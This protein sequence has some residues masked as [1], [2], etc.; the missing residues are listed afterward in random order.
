MT[1][2]VPL[3]GRIF[4]REQ[5]HEIKRNGTGRD[6]GFLPKAS[7]W[8]ATAVL[9]LVANAQAGAECKLPDGSRIMGGTAV[10]QQDFPWQVALYAEGSFICGGSLIAAGWVLTAAH[11]VEADLDYEPFNV[12]L[13]RPSALRVRHGATDLGAKGGTWRAVAAVHAH[14]RYNGEVGREGADGDIALLR[15]AAPVGNAEKAYGGL[16]VSASAAAKLVVPGTCAL[17]SG[18]GHRRPGGSVSKQLQAASV[19]IVDQRTCRAQL[20]E[21]G[22]VISSG[23]LCAGWPAGGRDTCS[24]DSGGPLVVE[25]L[26]PGQYIL[27]GVTSWGSGECGQK[28]SSGVYARVAHYMPWIR[29]MVGGG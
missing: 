24:G 2:R 22:N 9:L 16:L 7:R 3:W 27:A 8:A 13:V 19:L 17:V 11:C 25:G 28:G 21:H 15:L 4:L 5:V 18:W 23:E 29:R 6:L 10:R 1:G 26:G 20:S 14:P 12:Q